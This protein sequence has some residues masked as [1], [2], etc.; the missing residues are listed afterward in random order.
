LGMGANLKILTVEKK[1][2][3]LVPNGALKNVDTRKAVRVVAPDEPRDVIVEIGVT[4]GNET[5][6]VSGVN[7]GDLVIRQSVNQ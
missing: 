3:L 4:D 7:E 6:I 1:G 2:V 5:E